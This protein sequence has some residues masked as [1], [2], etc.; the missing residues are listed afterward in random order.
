MP[1]RDNT[2]P[3][4]AGERPR[5]PV[6]LMGRC[7]AVVER[8]AERKTAQRCRKVAMWRGRRALERTVSFTL[9][10]QILWRVGALGGGL[11][12][13]EWECNRLVVSSP[14]SLEGTAWYFDGKKLFNHFLIEGPASVSRFWVSSVYDTLTVSKNPHVIIK[15]ALLPPRRKS[16]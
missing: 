4:V 13:G 5:P 1:K 10:V 3:I 11:G 12:E 9:R 14:V 2:N 15:V 16:T 6:N 7:G 8:G